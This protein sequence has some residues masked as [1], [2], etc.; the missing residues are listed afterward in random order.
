MGVK[1]IKIIQTRGVRVGKTLPPSTTH[2][3]TV[4]KILDRL[5][6]KKGDFRAT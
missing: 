2:T 4:Q 6:L 3:A 5:P 1:D